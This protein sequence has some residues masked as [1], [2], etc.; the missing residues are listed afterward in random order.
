MS[1]KPSCLND[2]GAIWGSKSVSMGP[3]I[4]LNQN[5]NEFK[6]KTI[7]KSE[8]EALQEPLGAVLGRSWG[9][10]DL[11]NRA[12]MQHGARFFKNLSFWTNRACKPILAAKSAP[13]GPNL[14]P[15]NDPKSTPNRCQKSIEIW[16]DFETNWMIHFG[17]SGGMRRPPGGIIGGV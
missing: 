5:Q 3:K 11:Q 10:S 4:D 6:F 14:A 1:L 17:P 7:F 2:F 9:G 12:P 8:K 13:N 15:Q 16:I